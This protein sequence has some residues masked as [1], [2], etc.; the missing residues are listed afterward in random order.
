MNLKLQ[1][2][3]FPASKAPLV[4]GLRIVHVLNY[5]KSHKKIEQDGSNKFGLGVYLYSYFSKY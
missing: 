1:L 5:N 2:L 4:Q 3:T